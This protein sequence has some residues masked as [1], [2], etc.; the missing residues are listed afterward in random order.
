MKD[1]IQF[2]EYYWNNGKLKYKHQYLNGKLHGEQ[3]SYYNNGKLEYKNYYI[4]GKK[5]G[6]Q[7]C[8][9]SNGQLR[10]K[11]QFLNGK[12]V[13]HRFNNVEVNSPHFNIL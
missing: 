2:K 3:L 9:W 7:I 10:H 6:E 8:Y 12:R 1:K 4:N 11:F 5:H 13:S